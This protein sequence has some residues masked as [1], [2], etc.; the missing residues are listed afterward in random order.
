ML[1]GN[2]KTISLPSLVQAICLEQ[3]RAALFLENQGLEGVMYFDVGQIAHAS[4][5]GLVGD[6]AVIELAGWEEGSFHIRSYEV[7]PRRT[8]TTSW[9]QL[10][11]EGMRKQDEQR[12]KPD[13]LQKDIHLT[14]GQIEHDSRVENGL[15]TMLS[16]LEHVRASLPTG[17]AKDGVSGIARKMVEMVTTVDR[18]LDAAPVPM[19]KVGAGNFVAPKLAGENGQN[20]S[21]YRESVQMLKLLLPSMEEG[22]SL[23]QTAAEYDPF[24]E[25]MLILLEGYFSLFSHHYYSPI[26]ADQWIEAST[27]FVS[28]LRDTLIDLKDRR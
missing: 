22:I 3:R 13:D 16:N 8:I 1:K 4:L 23:P 26:A 20:P 14:E 7:L 11:M 2:L 24:E 12:L 9:N 15:I 10:L 6:E 5:G 25:R 17:K 19:D 18:Y 27:I 21:T 28:E